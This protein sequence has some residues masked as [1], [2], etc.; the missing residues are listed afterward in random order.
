MYA[1]REVQCQPSLKLGIHKWLG[2]VDIELEERVRF[3]GEV[4][5]STNVSFRFMGFSA[6]L[7]GL[8]SVII[9]NLI[10]ITPNCV[11]LCVVRFREV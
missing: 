2:L 7:S 5:M 11:S 10:R 3:S 4:S 9:R 8:R 6:L 1:R